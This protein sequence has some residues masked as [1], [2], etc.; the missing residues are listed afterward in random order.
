M[1]GDGGD[2]IKF[3]LG[4]ALVVLFKVYSENL[5]IIFDKN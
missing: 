1:R 4:L 3:L 5:I 2:A